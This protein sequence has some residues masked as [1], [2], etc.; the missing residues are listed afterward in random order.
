M[1][2][3]IKS[4]SDLA[5]ALQ[6]LGFPY[7]TYQMDDAMWRNLSKIIAEVHASREGLGMPASDAVL[8]LNW[9]AKHMYHG[10][11]ADMLRDVKAMQPSE[12]P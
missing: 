2:T 4:T 10:S 1:I 11:V 7:A 3:V 12:A 6:E 8:V 5:K 9:A